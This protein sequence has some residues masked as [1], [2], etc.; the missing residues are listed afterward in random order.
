MQSCWLENKAKN[1]GAK[2][3]NMDQM[4]CAEFMEHMTYKCPKFSMGCFTK[5]MCSNPCVC[6]E[7]KQ[8]RCGDHPKEDTQKDIDGWSNGPDYSKCMRNQNSL[9]QMQANSTRDALMRS[10][11][12]LLQQRQ[13]AAGSEGTKSSDTLTDADLEGALGTKCTA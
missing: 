7:W 5:I 12:A 2:C 8:V 13:A 11:R 4:W 10:E 9:L 1:A 6:D 3:I